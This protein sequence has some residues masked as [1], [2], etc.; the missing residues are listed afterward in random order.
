MRK[1]LAVPVL[2][3]LALAGCKKEQSA[4]S[5]DLL[6]EVK[7]RLNDRDRK[8]SSYHLATTVKEGE[9]V[10][11]FDFFYRSPNKMRGVITRPANV[12]YA[13]DGESLFQITGADKKFGVLKLAGPPE[14]NALLLNK[15]F[16]PF[17][18]EGFR[19]PLLVKEGVTAKKVTHPK[20]AEAVEVSEEAKDESGS[21][22]VTYVFRY[23]SMDFLSKKSE[24]GGQS[25]EVRVDDEQCDEKL[26]LCVPKK[27]SQ[28]ANGAQI[29]TSELT[30][31]EL[32]N[33]LP[34][35]QFTP[36]VPEG[37]TKVG[38]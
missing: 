19:A 14:Q 8:L 20:A 17:A 38:G 15:T 27:L 5:A 13:F 35:D 6:S 16:A 30:Q 33:S 11:Q 12:T 21:A 24:V 25:S 7:S 3:S 18:P 37:Y 10:A 31:I 26:K 36:A 29:G 4:P 32:N 34:N 9:N 2:A 1:L 23:P 22:K 28:W